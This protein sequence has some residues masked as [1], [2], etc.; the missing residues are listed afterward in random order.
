MAVARTIARRAQQHDHNNGKAS[1]LRRESTS[2]WERIEALTRQKSEQI[3]TLR[4]RQMKV[5]LNKISNLHTRE[6]Q[7]EHWMENRVIKGNQ[8]TVA[9]GVT[10]A[11]VEAS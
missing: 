6:Q 3:K 5:Q 8:Y 9:T 1:E 10:P 7:R 11:V 2:E 4:M